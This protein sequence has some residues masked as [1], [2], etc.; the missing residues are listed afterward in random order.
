MNLNTPE[1]FNCMVILENV[2][3]GAVELYGIIREPSFVHIGW[4]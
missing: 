2:V 4:T 3:C 1:T